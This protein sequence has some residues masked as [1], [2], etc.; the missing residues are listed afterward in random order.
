MLK[1]FFFGLIA[2]SALLLGAVVAVGLNRFT[3]PR[4]ESPA[5]PVGEK[6][7]RARREVVIDRVNKAVIAFGAGVLLCTLAFQLM[8]EAYRKG[9]FDQVTYGFLAGAAMFVLADLWLDR[10]G[11]GMELMLGALLDGIP[12]SAVIGIGLVAGKGLGLIM[13]IAVFISNF[14]E[15]FSGTRDMLCLH[16]DERDRFVA[17]HALALWAGVTIIC[18]ISSVAGY[19]FLGH[20]SSGW[21][22]FMLAWAAGS[23]LAMVSH[24]M[25]PE[26]FQ[27]VWDVRRASGRR[28]RIGDKIEAI[29][30]ACGFLLSFILS[31]LAG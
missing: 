5:C 15:A 13:M 11:S 28:F 3:A 6:E 25:I 14:P 22:A 24:T 8:E 30:V 31:R 18:T 26:A 2:S 19:A 20:A 21:V 1:A 23:I 16:D 7:K 9:G 27:G 12:E 10:M 4:G 17:R 29:A